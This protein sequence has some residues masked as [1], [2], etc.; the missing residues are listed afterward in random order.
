MKETIIGELKKWGVST[1]VPWDFRNQND[2]RNR[3]DVGQKVEFDRC[4][5]EMEKQGILIPR[6]KTTTEDG[7]II[8]YYLSEK[9]INV[10]YVL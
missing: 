5:E 8:D 1:V 4:I 6:L 10:V 9:G 3:L 2:F 7:Q